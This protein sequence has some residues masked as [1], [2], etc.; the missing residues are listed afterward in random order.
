M[1]SGKQYY[2]L[3]AI[4]LA[5]GFSVEGMF[6]HRIQ[7][8]N[9]HSIEKQSV[10]LSMLNASMSQSA[11]VQSDKTSI[12]D[13]GTKKNQSEN[14]NVI[15]FY[16]ELNLALSSPDVNKK[17]SNL[18]RLND[19][20]KCVS[21]LPVLKDYLLSDNLSDAQVQAFVNSVI[22]SNNSEMASMLLDAAAT[23]I[24]QDGYSQRSQFLMDALERVDSSDIAKSFSDYLVSHQ[25]ISPELQRSIV[26]SINNASDRDKVAGYIAE[27]FMLNADD[28]V[29]DKLLSIDHPEALEKI[30]VAALEQ[31]DNTLYAKVIDRID[32]NPSEH[33]FNVLLSMAHTQDST[34][35]TDQTSL[36]EVAQQWAYHQLSGS[37]LD[38]IEKQLAQGLIA[39]HDKQLVW[40]MLKHSEDQVRGREIIA[41]FWQND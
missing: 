19:F 33:T 12:V 27:Q 7:N 10:V 31:G 30:G 24:A 32:S 13:K 11:Y 8:E 21:C 17:L 25:D 20:A 4:G 3:L 28:T 6:L 39:D 38:F 2:F 22:A 14:A 26:D 23:M 18:V 36:T 35:Q 40:E 15:D 41:K 9:F 34:S 1:E 29:R 37:R 5:F 16:A